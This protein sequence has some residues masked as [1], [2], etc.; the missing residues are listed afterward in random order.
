MERPKEV[1]H[2]LLAVPEKLT[3]RAIQYAGNLQILD[4]YIRLLETE[5]QEKEA[6]LKNMGDAPKNLKALQSIQT[7]ILGTLGCPGPSG[8]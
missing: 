1:A 5:L 4:S 3:D 2:I 6:M 7:I 8:E